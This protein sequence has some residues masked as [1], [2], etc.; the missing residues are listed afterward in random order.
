MEKENLN[1]QNKSINEEE[2]EEVTGGLKGG[3]GGIY[4]DWEF[5]VNDEIYGY[6]ITEIGTQLWDV[7]IYIK[8]Q[9]RKGAALYYN[10]VQANQLMS[11]ESQLSEDFLLGRTGEFVVTKIV[12]K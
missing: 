9:I 2:L 11:W 8:E 4:A 12:R 7:T 10:V 6:G 5:N 1:E 3:G